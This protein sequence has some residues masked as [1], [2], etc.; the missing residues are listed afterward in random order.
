M[1]TFKIS[2]IPIIDDT[3]LLLGIVTNRDLRYRVFDNTLI[4]A[5][6][7]KKNL[8]TAKVGTTLE[9]ANTVIPA[10]TPAVKTAVSE[11]N[12]GVE[13]SKEDQLKEAEKLLNDDLITEEEYQE[14]RK[15][16]LGL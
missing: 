13:V 6:M 10:I 4:D 7:T 12:R 1:Q 9:E 3:G 5:V 2:G 8:V 14:M 15:N 11:F 16:I